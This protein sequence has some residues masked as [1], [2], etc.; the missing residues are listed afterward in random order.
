MPIATEIPELPGAYLGSNGRSEA[1]QRFF[2]ELLNGQILES[3]DSERLHAGSQMVG[4][5][6]TI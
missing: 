2:Q 1:W 6:S 4:A 5:L 3:L